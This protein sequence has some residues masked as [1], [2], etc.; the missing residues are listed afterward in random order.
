PDN[1]V[2][3]VVYG[4]GHYGRSNPGPDGA[5]SDAAILSQALGRPVRVQWMR[6]EEMAWSVSTFPQLA[7]IQVGLDANNNMVAYQA[8]YHQTGRF[9]G[10]GLGALLAGLPPGAVEDGSPQ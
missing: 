3:K 2:V 5:E 7:D 6:S 8:D 9:D 10:R 1:V 4:S